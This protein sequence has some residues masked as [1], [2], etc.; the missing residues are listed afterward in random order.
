MV[1][2]ADIA[3]NWRGP[4]HCQGLTPMSLSGFD[5]GRWRGL[6]KVA[7]QEYLVSAIQ[8]IETLVRAVLRPTKGVRVTP[9]TRLRAVLLSCLGLLLTVMPGSRSNWSVM[10]VRAENDTRPCWLS[11]GLFGQQ[12]VKGCPLVLSPSLVQSFAE[13]LFSRPASV[14]NVLTL[15]N[16][17]V[18]Y[19]SWR[20]C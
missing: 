14:R 20:N 4:V 16:N 12:A 15:W 13:H 11:E 1:P 7:I 17:I 8:N 10:T 19:V 2:P 3:K 18:E 9:L 6:W 5:R